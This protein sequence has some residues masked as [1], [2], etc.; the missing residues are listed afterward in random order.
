MQSL[1]S[2]ASGTTDNCLQ[3]VVNF[4]FTILITFFPFTFFKQETI[5]IKAL[6]ATD[7]FCGSIYLTETI[8]RNAKQNHHLLTLSNI[9]LQNVSNKGERFPFEK[10]Q[11]QSCKLFFS[12]YDEMFVCLF[13]RS[14]Y[15]DLQYKSIRSGLDQSQE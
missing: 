1:K 12:W 10:K 9:P 3:N 7:P 8:Q 6:R 15:A 2:A 5:I 4:M 14:K 11:Q 13:P